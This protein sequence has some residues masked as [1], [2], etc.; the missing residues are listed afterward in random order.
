MILLLIR[1]FRDLPMHVIFVCSRQWDKDEM[2]RMYFNPNIQGKLANDIQGFMDHVG[3]LTME[4]NNDTKETHRYLML[5]PG[6]TYQAKTRF[7]NFKEQYI[8][9]PIFQDIYDL[10]LANQN[11]LKNTK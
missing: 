10:E 4:Q 11:A 6:R 2:N 9:D 3:Y 8:V 5:N 7:V 1:K